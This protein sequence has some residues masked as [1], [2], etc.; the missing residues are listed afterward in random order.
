MV[1]GIISPAMEALLLMDGA[2]VIV[3]N[4]IM[5]IRQEHWQLVIHPLMAFCIIL[6]KREF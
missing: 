1:Y 5:P 2:A 3:V 6:M 4:G